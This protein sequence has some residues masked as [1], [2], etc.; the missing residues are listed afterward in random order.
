MEARIWL[1][2]APIT[3]GRDKNKMPTDKQAN[4]VDHVLYAT[5]DYPCMIRGCGDKAI[6]NMNLGFYGPCIKHNGILRVKL[7]GIK[8]PWFTWPWKKTKV[9]KAKVIK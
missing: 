2:A 5:H 7:V 3:S 9:P 4:V 6:L 8:I 1:D